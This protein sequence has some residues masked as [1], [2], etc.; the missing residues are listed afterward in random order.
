MVVMVGFSSSSALLSYHDAFIMILRDGFVQTYQCSTCKFGRGSLQAVLS[1]HPPD[2][3]AFLNLP[4]TPREEEMIL[5]TCEACCKCKIR[6][7][8]PKL[9]HLLMALFSSYTEDDTLFGATRMH[10]TQAVVLI[11]RESLQADSK[12]LPVLQ[13]LNSRVTLAYQL[14]DSL[15]AYSVRVTPPTDESLHYVACERDADSPTVLSP[16]LPR[17]ATW[18]SS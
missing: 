8:P 3:L 18:G 15:L 5:D 11:L 4:V 6:A 16:V 10:S 1:S 12:L 9:S 7:R 2:L 14:F 17:P 13:A